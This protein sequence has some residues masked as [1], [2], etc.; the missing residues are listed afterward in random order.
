MAKELLGPEGTITHLVHA[1]MIL[2]TLRR[3]PSPLSP[4]SSFSSPCWLNG[5]RYLIDDLGKSY[6]PN[7]LG[8]AAI[9]FFDL[10]DLLLA[11]DAP[12]EVVRERL[13]K[14]ARMSHASYLALK[15]RASVMPET[16]E[17]IEGI[18]NE[19]NQDQ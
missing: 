1:A 4:L 7:C 16:V 10:P 8:F 15:H 3:C 17:V 19:I 18:K 11:P 6:I 12:Q 5:R 13:L 2:A 9:R 14:A